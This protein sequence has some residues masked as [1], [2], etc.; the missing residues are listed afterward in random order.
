MRRTL[1]PLS[2]A[3]VLLYLSAGS[4]STM[5]QAS[6]QDSG[7]GICA[8]L[9]KPDETTIKEHKNSFVSYLHTI[10]QENYDE[11]KKGYGGKASI[12]L[13]IDGIPI[14][15]GLGG[16]Y[17]EYKQSLSK[18]DEKLGYSASNS[19]SLEILKKIT[20]PEA[21]IHF[22]ECI[23]LH[24][25]DQKQGLVIRIEPEPDP[26]L[27]LVSILWSPS[28]T[29]PSEV[30]VTQST[31]ST[32]GDSPQT[33]LPKGEVLYHD[34]WRYIVLKRKPGASVSVTLDIQGASAHAELP[35]N[36]KGVFDAI[37]NNDVDLV[38][39]YLDS[40]VSP[41]VQDESGGTAFYEA[42][43]SGATDIV[44]AMLPY[45]PNVNFVWH[46]T[47]SA[48]TPLM[49]TVIAGHA[50]TVKALLQIPGINKNQQDIVGQTAFH[51]SCR[52][53]AGYAG[54]IAVVQALINGG[55]DQSVTDKY[56][57]TA[58]KHVQVGETSKV[59]KAE[60]LQ[61]LTPQAN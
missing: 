37:A 4:R 21:Y 45:N 7:E 39:E 24:H 11:F 29:S 44:K 33:L 54:N 28:G 59:Y 35:S 3:A 34:A 41:N 8:L 2:F 1:L 51:K 50:D 57:Y 30:P 52:N 40:G 32:I 36:T 38:K 5:P 46:S 48:Y 22:V 15:F 26:K 55:V 42:A 12:A 61:I 60:L 31:V 58:W 53:D 27:F 43:G 10:N 6:C 17:D 9:L 14:S 25:P 49:C 13:P 20:P 56:G 23:K 18:L 47:E 16:N 19:E